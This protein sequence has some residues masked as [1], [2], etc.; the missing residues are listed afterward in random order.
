MFDIRWI[1]EEPQTFDAALRR[2][3]L[4]PLSDAV[5]ALDVRR[6]EAQTA[7]Q[8]MQTRRNE[9]SK[10]IGEAKRKGAAATALMAEVAG[11]KDR[12]AAAAESDRQHPAEPQDLLS[13]IPHATLP[14]VPPAADGSPQV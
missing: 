12:M 5:L 3:G 9:A 8:S 2:R 10:A 6:R 11:L 4:A 13:G 1:R 7:L 14:E